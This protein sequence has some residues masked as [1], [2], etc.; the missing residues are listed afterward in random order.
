MFMVSFVSE[1]FDSNE[2]FIVI[3]LLMSKV[4]INFLVDG[5]LFFGVGLF[6]VMVGFVLFV[7]CVNFVNLFFVC[8]VV[9]C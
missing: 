2:N 4:F 8:V 6:L 5:I 3:L 1:Y 7:V 9:R